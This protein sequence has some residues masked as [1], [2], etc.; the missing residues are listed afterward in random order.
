MVDRKE[1]AAEM[2][3]MDT[4]KEKVCYVEAG[5]VFLVLG[6]TVLVN[7]L[8]T[9]DI[10]SALAS[11]FTF[12]C[13]QIAFDMNEQLQAVQGGDLS[14]SSKYR[15]LFMVKE[16]LWVLTCVVLGSLP[17]LASTGVFASYPYWRRKLRGTSRQLLA[18]GVAF[19]D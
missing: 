14:R 4:L 11:L 1:I 19:P 9:P 16:C 6:G 12:M 10:L 18:H 5:I 7:G 8:K 3:A 15:A 13:T 17:L 2:F